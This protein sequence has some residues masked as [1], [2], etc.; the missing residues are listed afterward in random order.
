MHRE[1]PPAGGHLLRHEIRVAAHLP[2]ILA[3]VAERVLQDMTAQVTNPARH[4]E[5]L[6]HKGISVPE[7]V[8]VDKLWRTG[9]RVPAALPAPL[10]QKPILPPH[11][12]RLSAAP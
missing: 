9:V 3:E 12:Q 10:A 2:Q 11:K 7:P 5:S 1:S 6:M 4:G 8:L